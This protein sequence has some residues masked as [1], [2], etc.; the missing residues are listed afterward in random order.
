MVT[1]LIPCTF[2]LFSEILFNIRQKCFVSRCSNPRLFTV[3]QGR[4]LCSLILEA[5]I[6]ESNIVSTCFTFFTSTP[7]SLVCIINFI[8]HNPNFILD[9][10]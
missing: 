5:G 9:F 10:E 8:F 6:S 3:D 2:W 1:L 4:S 7:N